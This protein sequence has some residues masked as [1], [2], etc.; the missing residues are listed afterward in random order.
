MSVDVSQI[1]PVTTR[2][3]P[4]GLG[5]ANFA[6]AFLFAPEAELPVG[7]DADTIRTYTDLAS[8]GEDFASTTETYKA[9]TRWFSGP[10][11]VN[12]LVVYGVDA[13]DAD[14]TTTLN[15]ARDSYWWYWS[16][17]TS[18]VYADE[19]SVLEIATWSDANESFFINCQT[20][21]AA[22]EIRTPGSTTSIAYQLTAAGYRHALTFS[23]ATDAYAGVALAKHFA[24][25]NYSGSNT[26]ITGEY[27]KLPG[28][29]AEDLSAT[30]NAAMSDDSVRSAFYTVVDN[31][32]SQDIGRVIGTKTHS[33]FGEFMDDVVNLDA[34]V[35]AI[36]VD[37]Y[38]R[39]AN[40]PTKLGQTP[41]GQ[42][43]IDGGSRAICEQYIANGYLGP[44]NY[45]D[46]DDG[47]EKF[48]QGYEILT[49]PEDILNLSDADRNARKAAPLKLRIFRQ[50]AIHTAPVDIEVY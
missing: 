39:V 29:V 45:I 34:F 38:N 8:L 32:G 10:P 19:A 14:I 2:I 7:F 50:G 12:E 42:S 26:T 49:K 35:N 40:A 27:K 16:F 4:A 22:T 17:F 47:I 3:S 24:T 28:V 15:K 44:R 9:A 41:Q 23:H 30:A 1:I 43:V 6:K 5:F 33:A 31:N 46:P 37:R 13:L 25:V 18:P 11:A 48:T 20:G 21:A 36:K